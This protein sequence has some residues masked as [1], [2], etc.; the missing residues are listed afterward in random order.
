[1]PFLVISSRHMMLISLITGGVNTDHL[2]Q[3]V[4]ARLSTEGHYFSL[5]N[6]LE[7]KC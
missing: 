2:V 1:M 7:E 4:S 6:I 3:A 5:I